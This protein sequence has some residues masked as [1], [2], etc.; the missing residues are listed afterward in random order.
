VRTKDTND[1]RHEISFYDV[2]YN[3]NFERIDNL[4]Y[5]RK[6]GRILVLSSIPAPIALKNLRD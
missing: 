3:K 1:N 6:D 5:V 2:L 4:P